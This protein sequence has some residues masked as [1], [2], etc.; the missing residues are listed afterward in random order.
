VENKPKFNSQ[1]FVSVCIQTEHLDIKHNSTLSS[2]R[3]S[4]VCCDEHIFHP[5]RPSRC[6]DLKMDSFT[7]FDRVVM[8]K[9]QNSG[10][11]ING[12]FHLS[13]I[14]VLQLSGRMVFNL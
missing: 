4:V 13:Y 9:L 2:M 7:S 1:Y 5:H 8:C 10:Y 12:R 14:A 3:F 6:Y 11:E